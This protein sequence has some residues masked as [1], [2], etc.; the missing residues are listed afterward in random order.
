MVLLIETS[1]LSSPSSE[2]FEQIRH[3]CL[4]VL[5]ASN[6]IYTWGRVTELEHF[7][8][9]KLFTYD[10]IHTPNNQDLQEDF[11][12]ETHVHRAI[13]QC[14]CETSIGKNP[15]EPWSLQD[16]IARQLNQWL[17]KRLTR[18]IVDMRLDPTFPHP[19]PS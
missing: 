9:F 18:S 5:D 1:H 2:T 11:W 13:T 10:R 15:S 7:F 16:A 12:Q 3:L 14:Q 19:S 17:D 6:T 4:I 8:L